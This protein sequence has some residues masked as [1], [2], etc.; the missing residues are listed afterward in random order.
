MGGVRYIDT[1]IDTIICIHH[2]LNIH[3]YTHTTYDAYIYDTYLLFRCSQSF[4][5]T[6]P[7]YSAL[8]S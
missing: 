7:T 5:H 1:I 6:R 3:T 8:N 2:I 4:L